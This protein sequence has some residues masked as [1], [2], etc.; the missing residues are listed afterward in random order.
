MTDAT[1]EE[2]DRLELADWRRRVSDL[3]AEVRAAAA[4]NP[5][6]AWDRWREVREWLYQN[7]SQ[8]PVPAAE[9]RG[10]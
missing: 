5:G 10:R 3:Y 1:D 9:R 6:A 2:L 4:T 7:H 8:S